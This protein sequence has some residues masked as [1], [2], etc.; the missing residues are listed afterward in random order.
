MSLRI[1]QVATPRVLGAPGPGVADGLRTR[2]GATCL[3]GSCAADRYP[4]RPGT[5]GYGVTVTTKDMTKPSVLKKSGFCPI[6]GQGL[7]CDPEL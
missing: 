2:H 3:V 1:G 4:G 5:G 6:L 7:G